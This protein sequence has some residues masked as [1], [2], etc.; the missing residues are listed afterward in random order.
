M[1]CLLVT[2][3][4]ATQSTACADQCQVNSRIALPAD[5]IAA[6]LA[7]GDFGTSRW[8]LSAKSTLI[9]SVHERGL[10]A[11]YGPWRKPPASAQGGSY[12]VISC[13]LAFF[14]PSAASNFRSRQITVFGYWPIT[15]NATIN[16]R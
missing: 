3:E 6:A 14:M 13:R 16:A 10:V 1:A 2:R 11:G 8:Q 12:Q 4:I 9:S 15:K 5:G 7:P